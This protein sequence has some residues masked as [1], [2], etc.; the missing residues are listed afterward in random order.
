MILPQEG[1]SD[2][3]STCSEKDGSQ[4]VEAQLTSSAHESTI[5]K[6]GRSLPPDLTI[7]LPAACQAYIAVMQY[8]KHNEGT[9]ASSLRIAMALKDCAEPLNFQYNIDD[10]DPVCVTIQRTQGALRDFNCRVFVQKALPLIGDFVNL[11]PYFIFAVGKEVKD[12][13]IQ[14]LY[15]STIIEAHLLWKEQIEEIYEE[16][17]SVIVHFLEDVT[18]DLESLHIFGPDGYTSSQEPPIAPVHLLV[19]DVRYNHPRFFAQ[20]VFLAVS[21]SFGTSDVVNSRELV[22]KLTSSTSFKDLPGGLKIS[23][24]SAHQSDYRHYL[25]W[26]DSGIPEIDSIPEEMI[27]LPSNGQLK[28][29]IEP[30]QNLSTFS[31]FPVAVLA[32]AYIIQLVTTALLLVLDFLAF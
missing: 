10:E 5:H 30:C 28:I 11:D 24:P 8:I 7:W 19:K 27:I 17:S 6:N 13:I 14:E 2:L 9:E 32:F 29:F 16:P 25:L 4:M 23:Y 12:W 21:P 18:D 15:S 20:E 3:V 31:Q 22:Q 1:P 26:S